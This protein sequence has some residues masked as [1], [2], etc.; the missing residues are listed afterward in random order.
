MCKNLIDHLKLPPEARAENDDSRGRLNFAG[1]A[2][3][4]E[5]N[6]QHLVASRLNEGRDPEHAID[7]IEH[8][9]LALGQ[10]GELETVGRADATGFHFTISGTLK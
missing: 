7:D 4:L 10:L 1:L 8:L 6:R 9:F 2:R 5:L 3:A